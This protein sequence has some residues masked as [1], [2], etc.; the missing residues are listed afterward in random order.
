MKKINKKYWIVG[1]AVILVIAILILITGGGNTEFESAPVSVVDVVQ[2]IDVT[3]KIAAE[4]K[5]DLAFEKTGIASAVYVQVGDTVKK[6][7]VLGSL[8][9]REA[10]ASYQSAQANAASEQA[11]LDELLKG[12]RKEELSITTQTYANSIQTFSNVIKDTFSK[13]DTALRSNIDTFF[14]NTDGFYPQLNIQLSTNEREREL[15]NMRSEIIQTIA[16]WNKEYTTLSASTET[17]ANLVRE[18]L[19]LSSQMLNTFSNYIKNPTASER[20]AILTALKE[21]NSINDGFISAQADFEN[22][23]GEYILKKAGNTNETIRSQQAKVDQATAQALSEQA[24]LEKMTILAPFDGI[25]TLVE[26]TLGETI[27]ANTI[28]FTVMTAQQY[29]IE[30]FVPESNIAKVSVGN[31]AQVT[32]DAY[33]KDVPFTAMVSR[34]DPAETIV[35]GIPTYKVTLFIA[36]DPR[37][38]SGMTADINI[39]TAEK[40]NVLSI[41]TRAIIEKDGMVFVRKVDGENYTEVPVTLGLRGSNGNTELVSGLQSGDVVVTKIK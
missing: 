23:R 32:L 41:P 2:D 33:G 27:T 10:R 24:I 31:S 15:E 14:D 29:K 12:T 34:I 20:D 11:K 22:N 26:P 8:D 36:A 7:Q 13:I 38:R 19:N 1:G 4:Q 16:Q 35:E 37:I 3:G 9:T 5:A 21:I 6:G 17:S 25:V 18:T 28:A 40:R 30:V 39:V